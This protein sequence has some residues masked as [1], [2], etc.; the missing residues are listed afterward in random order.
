M[1]LCRHCGREPA[2]RPRGLGWAC[3]YTPGVRDLYPSTSKYAARAER[4]RPACWACDAPAPRRTLVGIRGGGW[5]ARLTAV[6]AGDLV[7]ECYCPACFAAHGW[8]PETRHIDARDDGHGGTQPPEP[9]WVAP[10]IERYAALVAAGEPLP[11]FAYHE[12]RECV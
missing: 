1:R 11:L 5:F 4:E 2:N 6:K 7:V 9:P 10:R 3:F 8:P 12:P